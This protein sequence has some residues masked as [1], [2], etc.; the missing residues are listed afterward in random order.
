M[1]YILQILRLL[2]VEW[3]GHFDGFVRSIS[4]QMNTRKEWFGEEV[5]W[6]KF[7]SVP[8]LNFFRAVGATSFGPH[9]TKANVLFRKEYL[10]GILSFMLFYSL[11]HDNSYK[12]SVFLKFQGYAH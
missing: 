1:S 7:N 5:R 2:G 10:E 11:L 6:W 3:L 12:L 9:C 8:R 4:F